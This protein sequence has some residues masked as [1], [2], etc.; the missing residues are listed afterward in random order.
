MEEKRASREMMDRA[1]A[2][3]WTECVTHSIF[4]I[5]LTISE[6][7]SESKKETRGFKVTWKLG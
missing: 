6:E 2:A 1:A 4:P 3:V 7:F 5:L